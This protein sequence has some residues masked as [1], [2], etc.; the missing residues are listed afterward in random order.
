MKLRAL[1]LA[2]I[3]VAVALLRGPSLAA[4]TPD[5]VLKATL[6]QRLARRHRA[7]H[8]RAGRLDRR[9]LHRRLARRSGGLPGM[10]HAQ[11]HMMFRGTKNLSTSQ[12]GTI[13]TALGGN[14]Q[15]R[16]LRY[17]DA[18]RVHACRRR[19]STPSCASSPTA[20]ATCSMRSRS[21]RT[22]AARS[23]KRCC[24]TNRRPGGDFFRDVQAIAFAGHAVRAT[25]R[26]DGRG[27]QPPDRPRLKRFY[28]RWYAPEQRGARDRR[29]RRQGRRAGAGAL[30]LRSVPQARDRDAPGRALSSRSSAR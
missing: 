9:R 21:G 16:D 20:C 6:A 28:E 5:D 13:A 12:L 27:V 18:V 30:V 14:V 24:A 15:R 19:T 1:V 7:R 10:A 26:R 11:E 8:A 3:G 23:S 2:A 25:G 4:T 22:S 17:A 29:R